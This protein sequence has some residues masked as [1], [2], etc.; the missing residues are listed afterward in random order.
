[1]L[2]LHAAVLLACTVGAACITLAGDEPDTE[3]GVAG[4]ETAAQFEL[5][6]DALAR[7]D[8]VVPGDDQATESLHGPL[9]KYSDPARVYAAAGVWRI[10]ENGR[11]SGL[12]TIEFWPGN[13]EGAGRLYYEFLTFRE[14]G[15]EFR[16]E[17]RFDKRSTESAL[18]FK[19]LTFD[20]NS[21]NSPAAR[22]RVMKNL[23][24]RFSAS[25]E[26]MGDAAV[27]RLLPQPISRYADPDGGI[28]DGA[29]FAFVYGTNPEL[30]VALEF[31]GTD[32]RYATGRLSWAETEVRIDEDVVATYEHI[33]TSP[34]EGSYLGA[35][36]SAHLVHR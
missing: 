26:Y 8:V 31:D 25:E 35:Y 14:G 17:L 18:E 23:M 29:L 4:S 9:L 33:R 20:G 3:P 1:M 27:L 10:G 2:H 6:D 19:S 16:S 11:P 36:H 28:V 21:G 30:I 22:S 12:V 13:V 24:R 34:S 15:L 5:I 32:W 7:L